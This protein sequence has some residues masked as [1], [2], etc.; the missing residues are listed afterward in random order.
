MGGWISRDWRNGHVSLSRLTALI[1]H[2][3][4]LSTDKTR[5]SNHNPGSKNNSHS[6]NSKQNSST[7][8][9]GST[10]NDSNNNHNNNNGN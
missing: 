9:H 10:S 1:D 2:V 6:S 4:L 7:G 3:S 8:N 5:T